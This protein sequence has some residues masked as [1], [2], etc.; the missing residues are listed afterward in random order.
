MFVKKGK[1][2][3]FQSKHNLSHISSLI[4]DVD[5]DKGHWDN[6]KQNDWK[7]WLGRVIIFISLYIC[8]TQFSIPI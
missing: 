4:I 2:P 6:H 7:T 8:H 3:P 5:K 1:L